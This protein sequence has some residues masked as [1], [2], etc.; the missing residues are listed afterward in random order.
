MQRV[1]HPASRVREPVEQVPLRLVVEHHDVELVVEPGGDRLDARRRSASTSIDSSRRRAG[2]RSRRGRAPTRRFANSTMRRM[3]PKRRRCGS[4]MPIRSPR[5]APDMARQGT[6]RLVSPLGPRH[7]PEDKRPRL[8]TGA[9]RVDRCAPPHRAVS[10][11]SGTRLQAGYCSQ[12]PD[13]TPFRGGYWS[14]CAT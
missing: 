9:G 14:R 7:F 13:R 4:T 3:P 5:R 10:P 1:E 6:A 8:A 11:S 12:S 2:R